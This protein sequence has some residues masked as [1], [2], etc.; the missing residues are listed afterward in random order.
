[1][2]LKHNLNASKMSN[3][4]NNDLNNLEQAHNMFVAEERAL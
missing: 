1:M 2:N 4:R 3:E